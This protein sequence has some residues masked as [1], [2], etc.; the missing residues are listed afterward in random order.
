MSVQNCS[1][2]GTRLSLESQAGEP[3]CAQCRVEQRA[4]LIAR[5]IPYLRTSRLVPKEG[6]A[7]GAR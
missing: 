4:N 2:C 6:N 1:A 7:G 3:L 5:V